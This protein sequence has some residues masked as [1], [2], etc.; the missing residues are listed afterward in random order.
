MTDNGN[1]TPLVYMENITQRFGLIEAL[2]N[3]DFVLQRAEIVGLLGDN[4][5][6]KSTLIKVLTGIHRPA[7]GRIYFDG[8]PVVIESPKKARAMGIETVYQDLALCNLMSI[9]RNFYLGHEPTRNVGPVTVLDHAAM[10]SETV[11]ALGKIGIEIRRPQEEVLRLS[12]GERQ[13]I[14]I[15]RAVF[16]GSK[17]LILDEPTSA[18]SVGETEKVLSYTRQAK[19]AGLSVIF[20]T[21]NIGHVYQVADRFTILSHGEKVGDFLKEEVSEKEIADM[22]LG[23]PVP[24]HLQPE[25]AERTVEIRR[26]SESMAKL[27]APASQAA[28][29]ATI[30]SRW[31]ALGALAVVFVICMLSLVA[32]GSFGSAEVEPTPLPTPTPLL[33]IPQDVQDNIDLLLEGSDPNQRA[34]AAARLGN[35]ANPVVIDPLIQALQ[36]EDFNVRRGAARALGRLNIPDRRIFDALESLL[37]DTQSSV[38]DAAAEAL[39]NVFGVSCSASDPCPTPSGP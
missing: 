33:E 1:Q 17:L 35:T 6:G 5:A 38:R 28:R 18:L 30:R 20:I 34:L 31:T 10:N 4:G 11:E 32:A 3:V 9:A 36:D 7:T 24:E 14:A 19:R 12:G 22:I 39:S 2:S 23:G 21:H 26:L 15:G 29:R 13:S 16:F 27:A 25:V 37:R 8:Q